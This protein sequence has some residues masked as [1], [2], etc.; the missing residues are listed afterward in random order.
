M[1]FDLV[2]KNGTVVDGTGSPKRAVYIGI[3]GDHI[4]SIGVLGEVETKDEIDATGLVVTPGFI[5]IHSH[6]DFTLLV[7]PRAQSAVH[8]GVT[9]ELVGNCGHGCAPITSPKLFTGNIYGYDPQLDMTWRSF[10]EYLEALDHARPAINVASLVPNGNLRIAVMGYD[11]RPANTEE[12]GRMSRFLEE[13]LEA[14]AFGYSTG[15]ESSWERMASHEEIVELSKIAARYGTMYACHTRNKE[16]EAVEAIEETVQ[17]ARDSGVRCQVSHIIPRRGGPPDARERAI[18]VVE[19]AHDDGLDVAFDAHTRLH[20]ITNLS[21]ALPPSFLEA[22]TSE[23]RNL[24]SDK[25][26]RDEVRRYPS[27]IASFGLGGWEN[28]YLFRSD[29]NPHATGKSIAELTEARGDVWDTIL[30]LLTDELDQI[31]YPMVLC[32]SYTEEELRETFSH[33]LCTIGSDATALALDGPLAGTD[34]LGAYTWAGWFFRRLVKETGDFTLEQA[35]EKLTSKP[36]E[37][38]GLT[39]RGRLAEGMRADIVVFDQNSFREMGTLESPSQLAVG[40]EHVIV[41]GE[42]T[43]RNGQTTGY[44]SGRVLRKGQG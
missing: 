25:A 29:T 22:S 42:P 2:V 13:G 16:I 8:Q 44:R 4:K 9:T 40:M 20:G 32:H 11:E 34:F 6:S 19:Q 15:L 17:V 24:L 7:D 41:N 39:D 37:R 27:L 10:S 30:D 14:G 21:A 3:V 1:V 33:R 18:T 23:R 38:I 26:F 36:A 28:V 5:D 43:L 35:V 12:I 31:D